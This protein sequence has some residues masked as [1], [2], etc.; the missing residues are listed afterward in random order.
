MSEPLTPI[1]SYKMAFLKALNR[2][3][4]NN[5]ATDFDYFDYFDYFLNFSKITL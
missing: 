2:F 4:T 1:F 3:S 5:L